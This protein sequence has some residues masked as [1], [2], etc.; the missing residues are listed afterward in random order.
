MTDFALPGSGRI[1]KRHSD[2]LGTGRLPGARRAA[3]G[4]ES[5]SRVDAPEQVPQE[6]G[7]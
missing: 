6:F 7:A 5:P 3:D 2:L 4:E 1:A